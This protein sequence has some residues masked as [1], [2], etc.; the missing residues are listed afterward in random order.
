MLL[1]VALM[2]VGLVIGNTNKLAIVVL[3]N[4]FLF[5]LTKT[6]SNI[7]PPE[8]QANARFERPSPIKNRREDGFFSK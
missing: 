8:E 6:G 5:S 7:V 3:S 1:L 2:V 4:N